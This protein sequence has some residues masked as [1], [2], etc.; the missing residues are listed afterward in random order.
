M[1]NCRSAE[2]RPIAFPSEIEFIRSY[3]THSNWIYHPANFKVNGSK[4]MP[5][6]YDGERN[7]FIEVAG[8]RQAYYNNR[9][10]YI[11]FAATFPKLQFEIR[12]PDGVLLP[13]NETYKEKI[14]LSENKNKCV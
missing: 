9:A 13:L 4:Y 14:G 11:T 1:K 5:D 2:E 6:F 12:Y 8:T 3:F 7:V 10:K